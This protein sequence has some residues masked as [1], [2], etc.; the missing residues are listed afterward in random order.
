MHKLKV[1]DFHIHAGKKEEWGPENR[2]LVARLNPQ[3][4]QLWDEIMQPQALSKYLESQGIDYGVILADMCPLIDSIV[5]NEKVAEF[6]QD[7]E[8]LIPIACI[9]PKTDPYPPKS[10]ERYV[11]Q[12]GFKG[13]KLLPS[14]QHFY[15]ND[16]ALYP[17][18]AKAEE[19][20]IPV[21]FHI[22]SSIFSTTKIKYCDPVFV[23]EVAVDF[24]NLN[25]IMAHS[26]RGFWYKKAF[27]LAQYHK[28]VYMEIA[29]LPPQNLL[30]YF[31]ELEENSDKVIF[32]SDWPALIV[33]IKENI[34]TIKSLPL[35]PATIE[36]ILCLNA[37]K[38]LNLSSAF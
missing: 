35:N 11:T 3:F 6:C 29:G 9:N 14:Y 25:I 18:Y 16:Q 26:G 12:M 21:M 15:L 17:L 19:L 30:K 31:P 38:V 27:F 22:G 34:E 8:R 2:G 36:K 20:G 37:M 23:D 13:V 33:P 32:G 4:Y 10:L 5:T 1:I 28:N 7:Y 24:P